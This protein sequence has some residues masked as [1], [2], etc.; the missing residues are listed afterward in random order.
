MSW[1]HLGGA[2]KRQ[3][4]TESRARTPY[5]RRTWCYLP[6]LSRSAVATGDLSRGHGSE[7]RPLLVAGLRQGGDA[8]FWR[9]VW[10]WWCLGGTRP[11]VEKGPLLSLWG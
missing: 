3:C 5:L 4:G 10:G 11:L 2:G 8:D 6:N 9:L 7:G 1:A